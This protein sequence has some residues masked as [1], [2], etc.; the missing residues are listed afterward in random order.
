MFFF[1][2]GFAQLLTTALCF[3]F[4]WRVPFLG[5]ED[6]PLSY[7]RCWL[8]GM[9]Y[10][11]FA[12]TATKALAKIPPVGFPATIVSEDS[13]RGSPATDGIGRSLG[14]KPDFGFIGFGARH[15]EPCPR[16]T[17][18]FGLQGSDGPQKGLERC[19]LFPN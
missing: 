6:G 3:Y 12:G 4:V 17:Y 14:Y 10:F 16:D 8:S 11:T 7:Q 9:P 18:W 1:Q 15:Q 2:L 13:N 5:S 19:A